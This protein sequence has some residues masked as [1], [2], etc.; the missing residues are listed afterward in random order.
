MSQATKKGAKVSKDLKEAKKNQESKKVKKVKR[1]MLTGPMARKK[2]SPGV[3]INTDLHKLAS[4]RSRDLTTQLCNM[5]KELI[6]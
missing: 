5:L 2:M 3:I 1:K 4:F 6:K